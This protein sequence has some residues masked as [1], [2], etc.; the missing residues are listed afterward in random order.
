MYLKATKAKNFTYLKLV[1]TVWDKEKKKRR[2]K[3]ILNLGRLDILMDKGLVN[4]VKSLS[5]I[6]NKE[7]S[8]RPNDQTTQLPVLKGVNNVSE[9]NI[10]NYGHIVYRNLWNLF[11]MGSMLSDLIQ[12]TKIKFDFSDI[13]YNMV[14]N[15]LISPCSK[16]QLWNHHAKYLCANQNI[17][18][19]HYYRSL[20]V[21]ADNKIKIEEYLFQKNCDLSSNQ[22][23][24]VF[25]D[26]TTFYFESQK[27][28]DLRDFGFDKDNKI[29]NVHVVLGLLIDKT[30]KPIGF[31]L[32]KGNTFEGKTMISIITKLKQRFHID[33][34]IIVADKGLN[35]KLNLK[36][37]RDA[38]L[39]Y[40]ISGRLKS[41]KSSVQK[42]VLNPENYTTLND[43]EISFLNKD[44]SDCSFKYKTIDYVNELS[45]KE[46]PDDKNFKKIRLKE[47]LICTYSLKR[48]TK[49]KKDR[50]RQLDKAKQI[51]ENNEKSKLKSH[52]GHKKYILKNYS[53]D[54]DID[55]FT[56]SLDNDKIK[57][58]AKF[59]GY[60]VIQS[61]KLDL[62]AKQVIENYHYLYKIE[63]SF[64]IMKS[65]MQVRPINHWTPKRITGHFV[66]CFI[67]FLLER[68]LELKLLK[69]NKINAPEQIKKAINSLTFT[70]FEIDNEEY[71]LKNQNTKLASEIMSVLKVKQ[72]EILQ[73]K[74]QAEE[75][76]EQ[77][78]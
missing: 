74:T 71:F 54:V 77:V 15:Q 18:L 55:N 61:S 51:I 78:F 69:H 66:M 17:D 62:S 8:K 23:D 68:E 12:N 14:I 67:A 39:H 3:V 37:I 11:D 24:V 63:E 6:V 31:E 2:H 30:G 32:F 19:Q 58:E 28:D 34:I 9:G 52:K 38:D 29:N 25:Y 59:D 4:I 41:M 33:T 46:N 35:S 20:D 53:K 21:L 40:I 65:T 50:E 57:N 49:D 44:D 56:M 26:V 22:L 70:K 16:L 13:V 48:A 10:L 45:Y 72:P 64:R 36:E 5:N 47:K 42:I 75:Y 27:Q 73:T 60:Y 43:K 7:I 76:M 1:E